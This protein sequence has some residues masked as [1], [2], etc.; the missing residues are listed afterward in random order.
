[1]PIDQ[2]VSIDELASFLQRNAISIKASKGDIKTSI[3]LIQEIMKTFAD[4]A[5]IHCVRGEITPNLLSPGFMDEETSAYFRNKIFP[6]ITQLL[7][8][9]RGDYEAQP[10]RQLLPDYQ[11]AA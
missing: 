8:E 11:P 9:V 1:M 4:V 5:T 10:F 7:G 3:T 6:R 2:A